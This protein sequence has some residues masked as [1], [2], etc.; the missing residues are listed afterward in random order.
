MR[1][2][3]GAGG[4]RL[5]M[6]QDPPQCSCRPSVDVL[7]ESV[8]EVYGAN[9]LAVVL[10]GMGSDGSR[11]SERIHAA[12]G[13]VIVQDEATSVVWGM[14]GQVAAA[15]LADGIF[16][17]AQIAGEMGRRTHRQKAPMGSQMPVTFEEN[18]T[19]GHASLTMSLPHHD[20]RS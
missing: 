16:P 3:R 8:A 17:L 4:V 5:V 1:V 20:K 11:G 15:G 6:S 2:A 7:F 18:K 12:G 14:P 19:G 9:V 13:Q 10:T